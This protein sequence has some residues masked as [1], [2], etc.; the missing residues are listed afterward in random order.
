MVSKKLLLPI[1]LMVSLLASQ[2]TQAQNYSSTFIE[3]AYGWNN[4]DYMTGTNPK[5][6]E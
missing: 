1:F 3:Y 2:N 5:N 6:G 4:T